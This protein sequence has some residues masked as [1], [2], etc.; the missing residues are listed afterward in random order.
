MAKR[1]LALL[2]CVL[3]WA[4]SGCT[5]VFDHTYT[6]QTDFKGS[7]E[8]ALDNTTTVVKSYAA[9][10]RAVYNMINNHL[11]TA[12]LLI[13]GY[14]GDVVS[15]IASICGSANTDTAF[16]AYCVEYASYDLTQIVSYYEVTINITYKYTAEEL[17][18]LLTTVNNDSFS[19]LIV[20]EL[21][22]GKSHTVIKVNNGSAESEAVV[23][24]IRQACRNHPLEISSVP[25]VSVK[26]YSGNTSQR[27]Y[28]VDLVDA[29]TL[30]HNSERLQAVSG[31]LA[32]AA[33]SVQ[34]ADAPWTVIYA[35]QYLG[36]HC[37]LSSVG[38]TAYDALNAGEADS[39][40]MAV[41]FKALCDKLGI[42][43]QVV[44]G[45]QEKTPHFWNIVCIDDAY[46]HVDVSEL[47]AKG[48]AAALLLNDTEKLATCWWDMTEYPTCEGP[49]TYESVVHGKT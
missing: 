49:L 14:S 5:S 33:R 15:D 7:Q 25:E 23:D 2:F 8:I 9:L 39:E 22:A 36:N 29:K 44:E 3:L 48:E 45:Q 41:A 35:A 18:G 20:Q 26:V 43:C 27:I 46:Y 40:G 24:L 37:T 12:E 19:D 1:V 38:S 21:S 11:E 31:A 6:S 16:G 42:G 4:L 32:A 13:S 34:S 47:G 10:R 28:E 17:E 30:D